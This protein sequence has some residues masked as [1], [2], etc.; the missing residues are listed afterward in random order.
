MLACNRGR[1]DAPGRPACPEH[2]HYQANSKAGSYPPK[3]EGAKTA[4]PL[5]S[6]GE[7]VCVLPA[8]REHM[9]V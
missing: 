5:A 6:R 9:A 4:S 7:N 1:S 3:T 8:L 2:A